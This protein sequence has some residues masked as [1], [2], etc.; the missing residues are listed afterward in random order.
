MRDQSALIWFCKPLSHTCAAVTLR[1]RMGTKTPAAFV[2]AQAAL[3]KQ[4]FCHL[5]VS[6]ALFLTL[7]L[8]FLVPM[9]TEQTVQGAKMWVMGAKRK[10]EKFCL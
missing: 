2:L 6:P 5:F 4:C 8:C 3:S 9:N 10:E 1:E 7:S